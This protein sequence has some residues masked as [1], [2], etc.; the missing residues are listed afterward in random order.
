MGERLASFLE[1]GASVF[2]HEVLWQIGDD[3]IFRSRDRAT[4]GSSH[5]C[6]DLEQC[7]LSCA[8][9]SHQ[10]YTVLLIDLEGNVFE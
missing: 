7:T 9:L 2:G 6:D 10:G 3:A 1:Y 4:C 5:A 8:I